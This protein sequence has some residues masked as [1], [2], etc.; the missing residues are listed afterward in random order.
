MM[1][2]LIKYFLLIA[3]IVMLV[4]CEGGEGLKLGGGERI[5]RAECVDP[6]Y[7]GLVRDVRL[8]GEQSYRA[9]EVE[10]GKRVYLPVSKCVLTPDK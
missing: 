9:F 1:N 2:I 5:F 8:F 10:T 3:V 7:S 6:V 4:S